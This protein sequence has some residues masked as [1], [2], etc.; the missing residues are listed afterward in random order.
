MNW[1]VLSLFL[2]VLLAPAKSYCSDIEAIQNVP[3]IA[4]IDTGVDSNVV[5]GVLRG[6]NFI[7][8]SADTSDSEGHGTH[9]ASII[10]SVAPNASIVPIK[11]YS[12]SIT[13]EEQ[14]K[15]LILSI[16]YAIERKVQIINISAGGDG[17]DENERNALIKAEE[18]GILIVVAAGN[19]HKD[20][21]IKG[22]SYFPC[23]YALSRMICVGAENEN[24]TDIASFSNFG[25]GVVSLY[26]PGEYILGTLSGGKK[27]RMSGS[28]MATAFVSGAASLLFSA[29]D[30]NASVDAVKDCLVS[31]NTDKFLNTSKALQC[32]VNKKHQKIVTYVS[33]T[34]GAR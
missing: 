21:N 33:Q 11:Y 19:E 23:S 32:L 8:S 5:S 18:A 12:E 3:K 13:G 1:Y 27:A 20:L 25:E 29:K 15:N 6:W 17:F 10:R 30:S 14:Y 9:V 2:V 4:E 34:A 28:S 7:N 16:Y 31:F 24:F 22:N 26:A